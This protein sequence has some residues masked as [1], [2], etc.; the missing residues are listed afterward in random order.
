MNWKVIFVGGL[1]Y[2]I[3]T[4]IVSFATGQ[5]IHEGVLAPHYLNT[6]SFWRPELMTEPPQMA[7]LL[8]LWISTGLL[9]ALI[10]A[11]I[12]NLLGSALNG[13]GWRRGL[14]F[15]F[16]MSLFISAF[17]LM[18]HGFFNLPLTIWI[19]WCVDA[20]IVMTIGGMALGWVAGKLSPEDR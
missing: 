4:W 7:E 20:L 16:L 11:A 10:F 2:Y 8:P 5:L 3:A 1:V 13:P 15:G 18:L 17:Y 9:G 19:W 6:E 12:Y 14:I